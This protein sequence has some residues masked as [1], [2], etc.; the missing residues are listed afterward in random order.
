MR[1]FALVKGTILKL[2]N[3]FFICPQYL[4]LQL[5]IRFDNKID[6]LSKSVILEQKQET[7]MKTELEI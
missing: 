3:V 6:Q 2:N 1:C 4:R 7:F 5:L